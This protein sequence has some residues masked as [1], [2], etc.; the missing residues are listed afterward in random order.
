MAEVPQ[1]YLNCAVYLYANEI[2]ANSGRA[3][4]GTAFVVQVPLSVERWFQ[5]YVVTA[6][7]IIQDD[8][9]GDGPVLRINADEGGFQLMRTSHDSWFIEEKDDLAV[10]PLEFE[11]KGLNVGVIPTEGFLTR[12]MIG[13][14]KLGPGNEVFVTGRFVHHEGKTKNTPSLRF[15]N[16]SM[17]PD[18]PFK[19]PSPNEDLE[20]AFLVEFRSIGGYSGAPVFLCEPP[21]HLWD[22]ARLLHLWSQSPRL[23]GVD[24]GHIHDYKRV[25]RKTVRGKYEEDLNEKY[26][27]ANTAMSV[28]VPAWRLME[29]LNREDIVQLRRKEEEKIIS[30]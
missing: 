7:H 16:I 25:L 3:T 23:L 2:E 10:I 14:H 12:E 27:E 21:F 20:E 1:V 24:L 5:T 22:K 8:T 29:L 11:S 19:R 26:Y 6:A 15:G 28:V 13:E 9:I 17:M 18:E 30:K 4:G